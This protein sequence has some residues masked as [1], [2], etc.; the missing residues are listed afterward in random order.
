MLHPAVDRVRIFYD[1]EFTGLHRDTTLISIG[2]FCPEY[3]NYFYAEFND[4][5][6]SQVDDWIQKHVI[7]NL[8]MVGHEAAPYS[9]HKTEPTTSDHVSTMVMG[10]R[11]YVSCELIAWLDLIY[12]KYNRKIQFYC[13]C[14]AYDWMLMNDLICQDGKALYLPEFIDYI[15]VDLSTAFHIN[16]IDPDISREEFLGSH[17]ID[18]LKNGKRF[19]MFGKNPK[20]NSLWDAI[21]ANLCY[22][23]MEWPNIPGPSG[24]VY[25]QAILWASAI[26]DPDYLD[27]LT[28]GRS[29]I[30]ESEHPV[31]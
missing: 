22:Y 31:S 11:A 8:I 18:I 29:W 24:R 10:S 17:I 14:Y 4:Y 25:D 19:K 1:A 23:K 15:P 26:A 13:D 20:H 3:G 6:E 27:K 16:G 12:K 5:D 2:L 7:E 30:G 9:L 28:G 21:V